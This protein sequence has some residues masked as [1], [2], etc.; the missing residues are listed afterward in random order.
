MIAIYILTSVV[1]DLGRV[2]EIHT[3]TGFSVHEARNCNAEEILKL[4]DSY[5]NSKL[6]DNA[7]A[8]FVYILTH[9]GINIIEGL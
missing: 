1:F 6:L 8:F 3:E 9:G 7:E 4:V 2:I 5:S